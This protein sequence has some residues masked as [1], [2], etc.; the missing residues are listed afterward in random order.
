MEPVV[1]NIATHHVVLRGERPLR[2]A[3]MEMRAAAQELG[4]GGILVPTRHRRGR[5]PQQAAEPGAR[6][7]HRAMLPPPAAGASAMFGRAA[8]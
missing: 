5:A 3:G 1:I 6:L 8:T 2:Q 4:R 7:C